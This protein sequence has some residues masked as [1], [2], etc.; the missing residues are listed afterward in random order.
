MFQTLKSILPAVML[1]AALTFG[2]LTPAAAAEEA[3]TKEAV[4]KI[5]HDYIM[6]HPDVILDAVNQYQQRTMEEKQKAAVETNREYLFRDE[7]SPVIGNPEGDVTIVEFFDY[8]C[9]YCKRVLP[10]VQELINEDKNI[11]VIFKDIPILGPTSETAAKWALA[12]QKHNK[13]FEFHTALMNHKGPITDDTLSKIATDL[14]LDPARLKKDAETT[15]VLL[16]IERNRSLF[17]QMGLGGTPAFIIG[18][19][20]VPGAI[21]KDEMLKLIEKT[22]AQNKTGKGEK[23]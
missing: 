14:E 3:L 7:R 8:N 9:G 20:V 12:A 10:T 23:K 21:G 22:R 13:Y 11:K 19:E 5:V 6:E 4:E 17:T 2:V 15:D 18:D 16:Q 1:T